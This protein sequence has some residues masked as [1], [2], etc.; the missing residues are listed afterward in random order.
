MGNAE[1]LNTFAGT[2]KNILHKDLVVVSDYA[3]KHGI[4]KTKV[5]RSVAGVNYM[6]RSVLKPMYQV[7]ENG[8]ETV[9]H[10]S[11]VVG[12][13]PV[14]SGKFR[15]GFN[16]HEGY[17]TYNGQYVFFPQKLVQ[18]QLNERLNNLYDNCLE[19]ENHHD[20]LIKPAF[21]QGGNAMP[22]VVNVKN[23]YFYLI[24]DS[25]ELGLFWRDDNQNKNNKNQWYSYGEIVAV[26]EDEQIKCPNV[27]YTDYGYDQE[28]F[29]NTLKY[30]YELINKTCAKLKEENQTQTNSER[31]IG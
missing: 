1:K 30:N 26:R 25:L 17:L 23:D 12:I 28:K 8:K 13:T 3:I 18:D 4:R 2:S 20:R 5:F 21:D 15:E 24:E 31:K 9:A 29:V 7:D 6:K 16:T 27:L 10:Y 11:Q 22:K 14:I 19:F